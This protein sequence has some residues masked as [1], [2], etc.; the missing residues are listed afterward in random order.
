MELAEAA[1]SDD[2]LSVIQSTKALDH[3]PYIGSSIDGLRL[4]TIL[5][6]DLS[7]EEPPYEIE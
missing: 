7:S 6:P 3:G 4:E 1:K 5:E 2:D